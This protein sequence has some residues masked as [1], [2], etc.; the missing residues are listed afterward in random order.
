MRIVDT[1]QSGKTVPAQTDRS[2]STRGTGAAGSTG[3]GSGQVSQSGDS[4]ELSGLSGRVSATLQADSASRAE[5]VSQVAAAVQSGTYHVDAKA[6]SKSI[7]D[8]ALASGDADH[9]GDSR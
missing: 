3:S 2:G 6:V 5:K 9:D 7:V 4:V 8:H 1:N